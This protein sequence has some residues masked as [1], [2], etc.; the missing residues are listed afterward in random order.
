MREEARLKLQTE[1]DEQGGNNPYI[2]V[3]GNFLLQHLDAHPAAAEQILNPDK[4]I[5]KSLDEMRSEAEKKRSGN[6]AILTDAEGFA[7][8]LKYFN[9]EG[10]NVLPEPAGAIPVTT[11]PE[12]DVRLEDL[13]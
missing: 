9:I 10:E 13:L 2:Q 1:I 8:V 12:F 6:C 3:V 4:T 11:K 5:I 7:I